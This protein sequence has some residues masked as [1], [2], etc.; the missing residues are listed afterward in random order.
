MPT[1]YRPFTVRMP[2]AQQYLVRIDLSEVD[3]TTIASDS[4]L[5]EDEDGYDPVVAAV[6]EEISAEQVPAERRL[7]DE[8]FAAIFR[9]MLGPTE[10]QREQLA[11]APRAESTVGPGGMMDLDFDLAAGPEDDDTIQLQMQ[12]QLGDDVLGPVEIRID[13]NSSIYVAREDMLAI[14]PVPVRAAERLEGEFVELA[15]LRDAGVDLR[16]DA[17][18]DRLVLVQ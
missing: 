13:T 1:E 3:S 18:A 15:S 9:G 7:S 6:L 16:Y 17:T 5:P 2:D 14:L 11:V 10:P 8:E 4:S 12:V